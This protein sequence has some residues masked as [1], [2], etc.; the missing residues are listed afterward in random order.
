MGDIYKF[1]GKMRQ[2]IEHYEGALLNE[3]HKD[4]VQGG[5][6]W[7]LNPDTG[8]INI[9]EIDFENKNSLS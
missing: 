9:Q 7:G 2:A 3:I 6:G 8:V 1:Q 5:S 4:I